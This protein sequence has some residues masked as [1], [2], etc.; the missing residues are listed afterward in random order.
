MCP[1]TDDFDSLDIGENL[2]DEAMLDVDAA[3]AGASEV[4][5][6]LFKARGRFVRILS[7]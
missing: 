5:D 6:E 4:A 1:H 3:G 7:E 2:V